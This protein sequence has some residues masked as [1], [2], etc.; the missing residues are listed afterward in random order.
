M[1]DYSLNRYKF[2]KNNEALSHLK[3]EKIT[4][5]DNLLIIQELLVQLTN[6]SMQNTKIFIS[7]DIAM[8]ATQF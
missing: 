2:V 8:I 1:I 5:L 3:V 6:C 7:H 4:P